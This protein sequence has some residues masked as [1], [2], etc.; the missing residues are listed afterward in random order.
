[1]FGWWL[2]YRQVNSE[3]RVK[4]TKVEKDF[5]RGSLVQ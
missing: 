3:V 2:E 5:V 4:V 1:M